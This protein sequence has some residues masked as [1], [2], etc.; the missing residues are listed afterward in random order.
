[1]HRAVLLY[2]VVEQ[3]SRTIHVALLKLDT[4]CTTTPPPVPSSPQPQRP[5][6]YSVAMSLAIIKKQKIMSI[7]EDMEKLEFSYNI[8]G[9]V[10]GGSLHG[11]LYGGFKEKIEL[12]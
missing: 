12:P 6:F 7:D 5:P 2:D 11:K 1:M 9:N 4:R 3:S 8:G 10:K